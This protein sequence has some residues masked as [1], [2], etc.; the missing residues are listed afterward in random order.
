MDP[1]DRQT[2]MA[3]SSMLDQFETILKLQAQSG[4]KPTRE[5]SAKLVSN[6]QAMLDCGYPDVEARARRVLAQIPRGQ[7]LW[8]F[9]S[10]WIDSFRSRANARRARRDAQFLLDKEREALNRKCFDLVC[11]NF[12]IPNHVLEVLGDVASNLVGGIIRNDE[13]AL[14]RAEQFINGY[15]GRSGYLRA[16][17]LVI[18]PLKERWEEILTG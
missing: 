11:S 2:Q 13:E 15:R 12:E 5:E 17:T 7:K 16:D 4:Y 10:P 18:C 1:L 9:W 3:F 6:C 8:K 14:A